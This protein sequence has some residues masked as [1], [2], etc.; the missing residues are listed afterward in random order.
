MK[1][2]AQFFKEPATGHL[3]MARLLALVW[4]IAAVLA[5]FFSDHLYAAE[6]FAG[7]LTALGL[8]RGN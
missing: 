8:R 3:S 4:G 6:A 7:A 5:M 2:L 1:K